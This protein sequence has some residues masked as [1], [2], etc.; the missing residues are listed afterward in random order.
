MTEQWSFF[1]D[2]ITTMIASANDCSTSESRV[3]N[4]FFPM[5]HHNC[6]FRPLFSM[7]NVVWNRTDAKHNSILVDEQQI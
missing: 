7:S 5:N 3:A 1:E 2:I 6:A 4:V